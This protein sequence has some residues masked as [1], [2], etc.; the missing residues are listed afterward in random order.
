[1]TKFAKHDYHSLLGFT[2]LSTVSDA[3]VWSKL[4]SPQIRAIIGDIV[5]FGEPQVTE[6][7]KGL[8]RGIVASNLNQHRL[9]GGLSDETVR[10]PYIITVHDTEYG[11]LVILRD[12]VMIK[13]L[14][15]FGRVETPSA[16]LIYKGALRDRRFDGTKRGNDSPLVEWVFDAHGNRPLPVGHGAEIS[17]YGFQPKARVTDYFPQDR[18]YEQFL[19][20]PFAFLT[21]ADTFLKH[22]N[23]AWEG[24]LAPGQVAA[25]I[26]DVARVLAK[27]YEDVARKLGYDFVEATT[28]H[29]HVARL[30]L[31]RGYRFTYEHDM[32]TLAALQEGIEK[33]RAGGMKLSRQQESWVCVVQSLRPVEL[34]PNGLYLGGPEWPQNNLDEKYLWLNL[35]LNDRAKQLL[36]EPIKSA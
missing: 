27:Q 19:A 35:P 18:E 14:C 17:T 5:K 29:Y 10:F 31:S 4:I 12:A 2:P 7:I 22:F 20:N 33:I 25:P 1:M 16:Q 30:V 15:F 11:S 3:T 9:Y 21:N 6:S 8:V 36:P 28:S 13:V 23:R 26:Y 24:G 32:K 34:I